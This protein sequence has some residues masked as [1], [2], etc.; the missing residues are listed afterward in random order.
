MQIGFF[1]L[2]SRGDVQPV[3]ALAKGFADAGHDVRFVSD[4]STKPLVLPYGIS[5]HFLCGN[6]QE[7]FSGA[8]GQPLWN[9]RNPYAL[10]R[11]LSGLYADLVPASMQ[12]AADAMQGCKLLIMSKSTLGIGYGIAEKIR[13]IPCEIAF[14][15]G[16]WSRHM[17]T[18]LVPAS[19]WSVPMPVGIRRLL[20]EAALRATWL[21]MRDVSNAAR[22]AL[23]VREISWPFGRGRPALLDAIPQLYGFSPTLVPRPPDWPK[24]ITIT[25][26]WHHRHGGVPEPPP[27]LAAFLAAGSKPIYVGFGS[28]VDSK[29]QQ[30]REIVVRAVRRLGLRSI[31][32]RGWRHGRDGERRRYPGRRRCPA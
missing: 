4:E 28:A 17:P 21:G 15:P 8:S 19:W 11:V 22:R 30:L 23:G 3:V 31:V 24:N 27:A 1:T 6:L 25:G 9:A 2:G 14:A 13:A 16:A 18:P 12:E 7:R 26:F 32:S 29:P 10:M 20:H 5:G